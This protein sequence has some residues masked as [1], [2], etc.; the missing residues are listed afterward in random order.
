MSDTALILFLFKY[1]VFTDFTTPIYGFY[2]P[3]GG[4]IVNHCL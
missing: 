2:D 1:L 4:I 3:F